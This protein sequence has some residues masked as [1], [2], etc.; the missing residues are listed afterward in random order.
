MSYNGHKNWAHWNV[1]LWLYNDEELYKLMKRKVR[2]A[3]LTGGTRNDAAE[4]L[5][6]LLDDIGMKKTPDGAAYT[7]TAIRAAMTGLE[8]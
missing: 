7:K 4:M 5:R 2:L 1:S 8:A 6:V 3:R